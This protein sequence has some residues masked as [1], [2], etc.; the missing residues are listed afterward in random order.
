MALVDKLA[1]KLPEAT[2]E[3]LGRTLGDSEHPTTNRHVSWTIREVQTKRHCH[4]L[5]DVKMEAIS[6]TLVEVDARKVVHTWADTV[7][8]VEIRTVDDTLPIE[9]RRTNQHAK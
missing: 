4:P 8:R 1:H 2:A 6:D 7:P 3:R 5:R 9:G